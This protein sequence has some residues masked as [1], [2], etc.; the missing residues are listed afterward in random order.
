[1]KHFILLYW[2]VTLFAASAAMAAIYLHYRHARSRFLKILL[3][4]LASLTGLMLLVGVQVYCMVNGIMTG[5]ASDGIFFL[6]MLSIMGVLYTL[7]VFRNAFAYTLSSLIVNRIAGGMALAGSVLWIAGFFAV[8]VSRIIL[9][10]VLFGLFGAAVA[11]AIISGVWGVI[12]QKKKSAPEEGLHPRLVSQAALAGAVGTPVFIGLD[13]LI[14]A[15]SGIPG[16]RGMSVLCG[17]VLSQS[18]FIWYIFTF[19]RDMISLPHIRVSPETARR[20]GLTKREE[21]VVEFL[22]EGESNPSIADVL[23]ISEIT[24]K[25]HVSNVY[26]KMQVSNRVG[27]VRKVSTPIV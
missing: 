15:V 26:R 25:T 21:Q 19:H 22:I 1:M 5:A 10:Y 14:T 9:K 3:A 12:L 20:Y 16:I 11:Y 18:V 6:L 4:F 13:L 2:I 27:L 23:G 7:V 17:F 24:V 8:P